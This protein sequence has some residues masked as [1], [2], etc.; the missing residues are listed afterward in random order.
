MQTTGTSLVPSLTNHVALQPRLDDDLHFGGM[1][2]EGKG[3]GTS[4][5]PFR[6]PH[7]S[8]KR[9]QCPV[10]NVYVVNLCSRVDFYFSPCS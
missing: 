6:E 8:Q 7:I 9:S 1:G 5:T 3:G 10:K 2:R 4:S